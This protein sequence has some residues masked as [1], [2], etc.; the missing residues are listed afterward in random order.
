MLAYAGLNL[1]ALGRNRRYLFFIVLMPLLFYVAFT[2]IFKNSGTKAEEANYYLEYMVSMCA[3][4]AMGGVLNAT[5]PAIANE[6]KTGW[7]QQLRLTPMPDRSVFGGKV[8]SAMMT[9]LPALILVTVVARLVNNVDLSA[10]HWVEL[11][12]FM[13]L[14]TIPFASLGVLIGYLVEG[15]SARMLT[16]ILYFL[17]SIFGGLW[18]PINQMGTG[19]RHFAKALPSYRVAELGTNVAESRPFD[20]GGVLVLAV[21]AVAFAILATLRI[22]RAGG[23]TG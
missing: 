14:A 19:L 13:W 8:I 9:A 6:R 15:E 5:G 4:G 16:L 3:F 18:V 23:V 22:R 20:S 21:Y 7:L 11:I 17:L 1:R 10:A 12:V 2:Q